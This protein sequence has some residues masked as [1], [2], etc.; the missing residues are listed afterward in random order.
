MCVRSCSTA[1]TLRS[2]SLC[3]AAIHGSRG[4]LCLCPCALEAALRVTAFAVSDSGTVPSPN[5]IEGLAKDI[6]CAAGEKSNTPWSLAS[7]MDLSRGCRFCDPSGQRL[8]P[9]FP[10]FTGLLWRV[11]GGD[12]CGA[13][14]SACSSWSSSCSIASCRS[15]C[16]VWCSDRC[17]VAA[18]IMI[19]A[20]VSLAL[21]QRTRSHGTSSACAIAGS[22]I[23]S[24]RMPLM[25]C[26]DARFASQCFLLALSMLLGGR[27]PGVR[28]L[29]THSREARHR[30]RR[31]LTS[32]RC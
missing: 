28:T 2:M 27:V 22:C 30:I 26:H 21:G 25:A 13:A 18:F 6:G 17:C 20:A 3:G 23:P 4:T 29:H 14:C 15:G 32:P 24:W 8:A 11:V 16:S 12:S 1:V 10:R 19:R 9:C 7:S 31:W 5:F